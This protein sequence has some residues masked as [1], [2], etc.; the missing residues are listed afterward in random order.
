MTK[1][2]VWYYEPLEDRP[3]EEDRPIRDMLMVLGFVGGFLGLMFGFVV[4][5]VWLAKAAQ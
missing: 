3:D 4:A 2:R 5:C 1:I